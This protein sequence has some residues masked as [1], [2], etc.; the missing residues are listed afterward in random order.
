MWNFQISGFPEESG[1]LSLMFRICVS[2]LR[3]KSLDSRAG[4]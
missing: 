4:L 3:F 1:T 2:S